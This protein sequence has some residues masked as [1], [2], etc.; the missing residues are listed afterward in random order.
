MCWCHYEKNDIIKKI[1][2]YQVTM[3]FVTFH[4]FR[5]KENDKLCVINIFLM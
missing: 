5:Y 2:I 1:S 3:L 4:G